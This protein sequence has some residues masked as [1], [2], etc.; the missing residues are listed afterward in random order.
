MSVQMD[1]NLVT[2]QTFTGFEGRYAGSSKLPD[3]ALLSRNAAGVIEPKFILEAGLSEQYEQLV[4]DAKL[5]LEGTRNVSIVVLVKFTEKPKYQCPIPNVTVKDLN[6][7]DIP[8]KPSE[9]R[10]EDFNLEGEYGAVTYKGLKWMGEITEAFLEVWKRN[11]ATGLAVK[12]GTRTV[13]LQK[14]RITLYTN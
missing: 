2:N 13:W 1:A 14:L 5:W 11:P 6:R 7:L 3:L 12:D 8:K 9:I 10:A 4:Q